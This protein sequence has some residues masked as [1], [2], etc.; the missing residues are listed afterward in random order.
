MSMRLYRYVGPKHIADRVG[1]RMTGVPIRSPDDV[2]NWVRSR[3]AELS[4]NC[5]TATYVV[6]ASGWLLIADRRSE[7]VVCAGGEPIQSA[8]EITF[9][10][11]RVVEVTDVSNQS[12]GYCPEPESWPAVAQ[13]LSRASLIGP[14][15]F[16]LI[17]VF[18]RCTN[19]GSVMLVKDSVFKCE[20]CST[21]L[22]ENYNVQ[23]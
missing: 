4:D 10:I 5:L 23:D 2:R 18:R 21:R 20:I 7:H 17:C 19:C 22:P 12:T 9:S 15:G 8:G 11:G 6:D 16:T 14:H 1:Q 13:A 3:G